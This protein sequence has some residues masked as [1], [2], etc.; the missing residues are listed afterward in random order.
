MVLDLWRRVKREMKSCRSIQKCVFTG[1]DYQI[2]FQVEIKNTLDFELEKMEEE[3]QVNLLRRVKSE[4][5][6]ASRSDKSR[7]ITHP[8]NVIELE[9]APYRSNL[10]FKE[11]ELNTK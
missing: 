1:Q 6:R 10:N 7:S 11:E 9:S 3:E 2:E 8:P 5:L 4:E